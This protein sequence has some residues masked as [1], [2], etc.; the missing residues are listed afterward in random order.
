MSLSALSDSMSQYRRFLLALPVCLCLVSQ[1]ARRQV[2]IDEAL[3]GRVIAEFTEA[4]LAYYLNGG[5]PVSNAELM[6]KVL[7][8]HS[9]RLIE[10]KPVLRRF[11]PQLEAMLLKS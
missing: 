11:E 7:A 8:R 9:L 1:C 3:V 6:E 10:F 2:N 5:S 4:R